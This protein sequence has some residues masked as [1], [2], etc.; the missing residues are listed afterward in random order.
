MCKQIFIK[1]PKFGYKSTNDYANAT[2][3]IILQAIGRINRTKNSQKQFYFIDENLDEIFADFDNDLVP[4]LPCAKEI[5]QRSIEKIKTDKKENNKPKKEKWQNEL[6]NHNKKV[7]NYINYLLGVFNN[8]DQNSKDRQIEAI[9]QQHQPDYNKIRDF[10]LRHLSIDNFEDEEFK[11]L[12]ISSITML[13][14]KIAIMLAKETLILKI[15]AMI[16]I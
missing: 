3:S 15:S 13:S 10:I 2:I 7:N 4:L 12:N 9:K 6:E 14:A 11:G 16:L 8:K 1:K 5:K